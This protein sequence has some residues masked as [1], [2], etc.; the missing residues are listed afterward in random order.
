MPLRSS[1]GNKRNALSLK[2]K[3]KKKKKIATPCYLGFL[4]H[5]VRVMT[6][7]PF[8]LRLLLGDPSHTE[9]RVNWLNLPPFPEAQELEGPGHAMCRKP[10]TK[11][12]RAVHKRCQAHAGV[13]LLT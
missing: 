3:K 8:S 13:L 1:L 6:N 4:I 10:A 5:K 11:H 9:I 12:T 7:R 2:K